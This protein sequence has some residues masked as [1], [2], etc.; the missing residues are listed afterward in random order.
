MGCG[1][2]SS[3][4]CCL[5]HSKDASGVWHTLY[6]VVCG[7]SWDVVGVGCVRGWVR[8]L[9]QGV[10]FPHGVLPGV[11]LSSGFALPWEYVVCFFC[12]PHC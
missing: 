1:R 5:F 2:L 11:F 9:R 12:S 4:L 8:G 10:L 7:I 3:S 6:V